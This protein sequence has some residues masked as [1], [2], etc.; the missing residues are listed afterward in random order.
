MT[1]IVRSKRALLLVVAGVAS[2]VF[3]AL[4]VAAVL[5]Q[6][7]IADTNG[8]HLRIV[9]TVADGF[10]SGWHVHPGIAVVQVQ[11]GSFR[12]YQG[13]CTPVNVAAGQ[14]FIEVPH[15]AVRA[16]ATGRI[17]WTTTLI[18]TSADPSSIPLATYHN[19][20]GY[21]PCPSVP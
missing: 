6:Q 12:I 1:R 18:T 4:G 9:R 5:S 19:D 2:C 3:A 10:D 11:E 20:S 16:V 21:N 7:V 13:S 17:N 15:I 8:V 14:T